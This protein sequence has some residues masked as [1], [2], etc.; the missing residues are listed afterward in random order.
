MCQVC[1]NA[2]MNVCVI[3]GYTCTV[4]E[5]HCTVHELHTTVLFAVLH[6]RSLNLNV[7]RVDAALRKP[8]PTAVQLRVL[9]S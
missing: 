9:K 1:V 2:Y 5:L 3:V 8:A 4:H 7:C 6:V